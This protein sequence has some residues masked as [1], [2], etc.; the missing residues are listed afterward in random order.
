MICTYQSLLAMFVH[1]PALKKLKG[2]VICHLLSH[3]C[4]STTDN[5]NWLT[6][7]YHHCSWMALFND[8]HTHLHL[9]VPGAQHEYAEYGDD[10]QHWY[11]GVPFSCF[12]GSC[13]AWRV[14][15]YRNFA[16]SGDRNFDIF[17]AA[18]SVDVL[19]FY[20]SLLHCVAPVIHPI[21]QVSWGMLLP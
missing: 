9:L 13:F 14:C 17:L 18:A 10:E 16:K 20:Y 15:V 12:L 6:E 11:V 3:A 7:F 5:F 2:P 1:W 19:P 4:W 21:R 8:S